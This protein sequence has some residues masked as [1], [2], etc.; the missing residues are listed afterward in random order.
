MDLVTIGSGDE[1][2]WINPAQIEWFWNHGG[3]LCVK[4]VGKRDVQTYSGITAE[5]FE[6]KLNPMF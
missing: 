1:K 5:E 4:F 2:V 3:K 6:Q